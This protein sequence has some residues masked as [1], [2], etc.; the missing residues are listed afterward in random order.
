MNEIIN[1]LKKKKSLPLDQF[2]ETALYNNTFGYYMKK[3]PLGKKGAFITSPLI[4]KL[5]SEMI[6]IWLISYWQYLG[7]PKKINII[8]L[9][10]GDGSLCKDIL[11]TSKNFRDFYNSLEI[12]LLEKS[13]KLKKIQK[14]KIKNSKVQWINSISEIKYGPLVF[15][16]NEFSIHSNTIEN[17]PAFSK[18]FASLKILFLS[19]NFFPLNLNLPFCV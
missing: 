16:A 6:V 13:D 11:D 8:E 15:L 7:K 19:N 9:G 2:I 17:T 18:S 14:I 10:P 12:K 4:T 3:N 1:I 5:F